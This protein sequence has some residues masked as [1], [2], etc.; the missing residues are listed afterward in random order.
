[1]VKLGDKIIGVFGAMH[2]EWSGEVI[3]IKT[4][5]TGPSTPE[6]KVKWENGSYSNMGADEI[7]NDYFI[8]IISGSGIGYYNMG[9]DF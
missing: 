7:R 3:N 6:V 1:M 2:A 4:Y 8:P 9:A 5:D